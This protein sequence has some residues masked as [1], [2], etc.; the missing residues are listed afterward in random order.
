MLALRRSAVVAVLA[1][2][3][4]FGVVSCGDEA[5]E[6]LRYERVDAAASAFEYDIV[7]PRGTAARIAAG[8]EV[9]LLPAEF[10][11]K[12][13]ETIRIVNHDVEAHDAG[14]FYVGPG[15]TMTQRF[16]SAGEY[17]GECSIHSSGEIVVRVEPES[18]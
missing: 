4:G 2:T 5:P 12:V 14:P 18:S 9:Q 13:G 17:S 6:V 16:A 15:E 7:I 1:I 10:V 11:V 3:T 8:D